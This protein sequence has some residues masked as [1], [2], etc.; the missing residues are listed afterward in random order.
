LKLGS[1]LHD[2]VAGSLDVDS[3]IIRLGVLLD[4]VAPVRLDGNLTMLFDLGN[5]AARLS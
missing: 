2:V 4:G 5:F 1:A 3:G